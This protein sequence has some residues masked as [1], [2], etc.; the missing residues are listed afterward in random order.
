MIIAQKKGDDDG[1][2]E[3]RERWRDGGRAVKGLTKLGS[4][5]RRRGREQPKAKGRRFIGGGGG[6]GGRLPD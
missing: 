5:K 4:G 6:G 3:G 2:R 1:E